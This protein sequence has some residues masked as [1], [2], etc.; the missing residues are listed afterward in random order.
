MGP[1]ICFE[2]EIVLEMI[3]E[4]TSIVRPYE[5]CTTSNFTAYNASFG[6]QITML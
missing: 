1:M 4:V 3:L 5:V 2:L 6:N